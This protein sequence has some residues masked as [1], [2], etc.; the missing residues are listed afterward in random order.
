MRAGTSSADGRGAWRS[1]RN[2]PRSGKPATWR[3]EAASRST[4]DRNGRR[5][6]VNTG[7]P[8]IGYCGSRP[9]RQPQAGGSWRAG[10]VE[11]RTPGSEGGSGKRTTGNGDTAPRPDPYKN[12]LQ[13]IKAKVRTISRQNRNQPLAVLLHRLNL[14]LRGWTTYFRHSVAKATFNYLCR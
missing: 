12:A 13:A 7:A 4:R 3:R 11:T 2:S 8:C 10:C 9:R 1:L 5:S 6:L 14:V